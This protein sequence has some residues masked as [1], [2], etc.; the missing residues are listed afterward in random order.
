M[1]VIGTNNNAITFA[2]KINSK[3]RDLLDENSNLM[4]GGQLIRYGFAGLTNNLYKDYKDRFITYS[5]SESLMN[6]SAMG[7]ALAG[8]KVIMFHVRMDF[9]AS[10]MCALVNHIPIWS[11]KGIDLPITM[12]CQ[13]GKGMGQGPQHSKDLTSW[14]SN[15]EG[16]S[17]LIPETPNQAAI[18]LEDSV[19]GSKPVMYIIHRELFDEPRGKKIFIPT[20]IR[21]CGASQRH[22]ERFY[23]SDFI[24]GPDKVKKTFTK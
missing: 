11:S 5:V 1:D 10:G 19:R 16:W 4:L 23:G 15:F 17:V 7:L 20:K 24:S 22:E 3:L 21:L 13:V 6:S 18:M 2:S 8:K 14:F 12:V 9:L